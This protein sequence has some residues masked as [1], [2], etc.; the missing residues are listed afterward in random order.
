MADAALRNLL[1]AWQGEYQQLLS[2][3]SELLRNFDTASASGA[4][5]LLARRQQIIDR[6][7][8]FDT[9]LKEIG[10]E[11]SSQGLLQEFRAFQQE[12]TKR[13]LELDGLAI[14]LGKERLGLLKGKLDGMRKGKHAF[15]AYE[16]SA[17]VRMRQH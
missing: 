5:E 14:A 8:N 17:G 4:A 10:G 11:A 15:V 16:Q 13:I 1:G 3:A 2:E 12:T 9:Q 7:Q 6:F